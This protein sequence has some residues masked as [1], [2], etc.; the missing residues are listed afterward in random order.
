[1]Y[2]H[3]VLV[4][5]YRRKVIDDDILGFLQERFETIGTNYNIQLIEI[6]HDSD[7]LH[8]LFKGEPNSNI[9]KFINGYK[10]ATS[11]KVKDL[12]PYVREKLWKSQFWSRSF[13]LITAG[14]ASVE[15]IKEYIQSQGDTNE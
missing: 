2:F 5:K 4:T 11:R 7:H 10:S 15:V 8:I 6:N 12:F 14:G 1:M 3:L 13:C 9:S